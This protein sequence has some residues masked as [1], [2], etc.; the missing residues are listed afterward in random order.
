MKTLILVDIQN[1]FCPGGALTVPNGDEIVAVANAVM[2]KDFDLVIAT[3]DWHPANHGSFAVNHP[4]KNVYDVVNLSG[5]EQVLW[6]AHCV[7]GTFGAEL[8]SDLKLRGRVRLFVKGTDPE[9][10]SYSGFF[11]NARKNSTGL[12]EY[13]KRCGVDEIFIMGLA[14]DYCVKFTAL[15]AVDLGFSVNVIVDGC[16]A[17]NL[18]CEDELKSLEEMGIVGCR[19]IESNELF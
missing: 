8:H 11:D 7:Q 19:L 12:G 10:D 18:D 5:L 15:D 4:G 1:D 2:T 3:K 17:V 16:R 6:P 13:L 9:V 14:T